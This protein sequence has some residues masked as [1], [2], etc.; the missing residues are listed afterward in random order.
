M[1]TV[2]S[3]GGKKHRN[4]KKSSLEVRNGIKPSSS[5]NLSVSIKHSDTQ[6]ST[7][8]LQ[9]G[10]VTPSLSDDIMPNCH[11]DG[12]DQRMISDK[13]SC[14]K[15]YKISGSVECSLLEDCSV[16]LPSEGSLQAVAAVLD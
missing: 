3:N 9:R 7:A 1:S 5:S 14:D 13:F 11:E 6:L 16:C 15:V 8:L 2:R 10:A 4:G 12:G